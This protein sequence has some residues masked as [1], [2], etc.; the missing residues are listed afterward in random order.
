MHYYHRVN[1]KIVNSSSA[2]CKWDGEKRDEPQKNLH[3]DPKVGGRDRYPVITV[4]LPDPYACKPLAYGT[5]PA[6]AYWLIQEKY[7]KK[8]RNSNIVFQLGVILKSI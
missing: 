5:K 4:Q 8:C 3:N 6:S 2:S 1:G 7:N